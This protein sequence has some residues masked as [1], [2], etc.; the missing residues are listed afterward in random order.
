MKR[1]GIDIGSTNAKLA[2][3]DE[4]GVVLHLLA[5]ETGFSSLEACNSLLGR[6]GEFGIDVSE[7][8]IASTGYGRDIVKNAERRI[9]EI[10]CHAKGA[11][12]IFSRSDF[13]LIDVGGQDTKVISVRRG[14]VE[15][16]AMNDK[17]SAG[18]GRFLDVMAKI[19]GLDVGSLVELASKGRGTSVGIS[20]LC[21]VF[22]ESEV[23]SLIGRAVP[24]EEIAYAIVY[25]I[26]QK[27]ASQAA[28]IS[29][30]DSGVFLTG[31]MCENAFFVEMLS[32]C[33]KK[34]V[35]TDPKAR[36]AG[37]IGAAMFLEAPMN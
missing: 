34:R 9:T 35:V 19:F 5:Q 16:F 32:E 36:Y 14:E 24:K 31:G 8:R 33:L 25:S 26:A 15:D 21:T 13:L 22:A 23:I 7:C 3:L 27:V 1:I 2:L 11:A 37:C 12:R 10:S 17:C 30:D 28:R 20:S 4:K 29:A 18:T 6:L